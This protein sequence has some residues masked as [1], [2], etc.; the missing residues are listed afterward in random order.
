MNTLEVLT[1]IDALQIGYIDALDKK[2]M[3]AWLSAFSPAG[4]AYFCRT[5]EAEDR[6][7]EISFIYDD[8]YDR[9]QDRVKFVTR[10]WTGTYQDYQTRHFIQRLSCEQREDG[11]YEVRSN[12]LVAFT[13]S[14]NNQT[15]L[16]VAGT[17]VDVIE[18]NG[19]DAKFK[20][21]RVIIDAPVLP[22]YIVYPL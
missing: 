12:L 19:G 16:L 22:H 21:K 8:N 20:S 5:A 6:G 13:R 2:D 11:C 4:S 18:M 10:V 15:E 7:L 3:E 1:Q 9:L 14:D 17:Y